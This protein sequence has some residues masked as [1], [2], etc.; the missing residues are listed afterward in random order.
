MIDEPVDVP[1][2]VLAAQKCSVE[3]GFAMACENRTGALLRTLAASKPGGRILE[4]GTGT[5]VGTAWLLAGMD[6]TARLTSVEVD[7]A[8]QAVARGVVGDDPRAEF[9]LDDAH[10]WL[11]AY[12]GPPFDMAFVDCRPGKF[13]H[14]RLLMVHLAPG[15]LYVGDD[16]LAQPTWPADH[17]PRVDAF[18]AEI[19]A[20]P[21][22]VVTLM[23]WSSGL[24]VAAYRSVRNGV[25]EPAGTLAEQVVGH[26][27][28]DFGGIG[29]R[30]GPAGMHGGGPMAWSTPLPQNSS[31][32]T[33]LDS[34][35]RSRYPMS[36]ARRSTRSC[37]SE[38]PSTR[39]VDWSSP[40][41]P[42]VMLGTLRH[43]RSWTS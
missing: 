25:D 12:D 37:W 23:R 13:V 14:R 31:S 38:S 43:R 8:T 7:W 15:A 20:E 21:D 17:Q 4:L 36:T 39:P 5:G 42:A 6:P 10:R 11:T 19:V 18:L 34:N 28:P 1:A 3:V 30:S 40:G 33:R 26:G 35:C 27:L 22:L 2:V 29:G 41:V 32:A 24:V 9:V 16:L